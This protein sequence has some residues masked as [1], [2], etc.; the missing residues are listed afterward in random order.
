MSEI[1]VVAIITATPESAA[2]VEKALSTLVEATHTEEGC[3]TYSLQRAVDDPT[4]FV[5]VEKWASKEALDGHFVSPHMAA[6][7]QAMGQ[8]AEPPTIVICNPIPL[9]DPA[10]GLF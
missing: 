2:D 1:T 10:K 7:G 3:L 5:T 9:G 8:L 4:K 6:V